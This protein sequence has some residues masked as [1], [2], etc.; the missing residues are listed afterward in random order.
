M[1]IDVTKGWWYSRV[2]SVYSITVGRQISPSEP[3]SGRRDWKNR[4]TRFHLEEG[5]S[6]TMSLPRSIH[7]GGHRQQREK[8][9][10]Q[11]GRCIALAGVNGKRGEHAKRMTSFCG[12]WKFR[13]FQILERIPLAKHLFNLGLTLTP[14]QSSTLSIPPSHYSRWNILDT[15]C[16][17][18]CVLLDRGFGNQILLDRLSIWWIVNILWWSTSTL[19]IDYCAMEYEL[20][21]FWLCTEG[22][23]LTRIR[24]LGVIERNHTLEENVWNLLLI[25]MCHILWHYTKNSLSACKMTCW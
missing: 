9:L 14:L 19:V 13:G 22:I 7:V 21:L 25:F 10:N 11:L 20:K 3:I 6:R 24:S 12:S 4:R 17:D 5:E 8:K 18:T 15:V 1:V 16:F 23:A 2:V